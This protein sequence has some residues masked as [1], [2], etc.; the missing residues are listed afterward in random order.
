MDFKFGVLLIISAQICTTLALPPCV[1][2]RNL[3][4]VCGSDGEDYSNPCRLECAAFKSGTNITL[5]KYGPCVGSLPQVVVRE[6]CIC[7]NENS[8]VCGSDGQTYSNECRLNCHKSENPSLK[9]DRSGP[10]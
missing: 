5:A 8:P 1:C 6:E 4:P 2:A 7:D 10:C 3:N 9:V